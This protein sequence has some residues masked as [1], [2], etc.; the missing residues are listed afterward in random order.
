MESQYRSTEINHIALAMAKAQGA[1]KPLRP[2]QTYKGEKYANLE[3]ILA[4]VREPLSINALAFFQ[5]D[6]LMDTGSGAAILKTTIMH[7]SGQWISS[8][9]RIVSGK[10]DKETGTIYEFRARQHAVRLLGIAPSSHDPYLWDD[11][12]EMQAET[13]LLDDLSKPKEVRVREKGRREAAITNQQYNQLNTVLRGHSRLAQDIM[14]KHQIE[15]LD[16]LPENVFLTVLQRIY[17]I[18]K[19]EEDGK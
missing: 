13:T 10:T 16:E 19:I 11:N 8:W 6:E 12:G 18:K 17:D 14:D 7:E 1:Y 9:A 15:S 3:A 5:H 2:N 4:A